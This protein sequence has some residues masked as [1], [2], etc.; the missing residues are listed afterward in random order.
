MKYALF[1]I[2]HID[3][4]DRTKINNT[5]DTGGRFGNIFIRNIVS[6]RMAKLNNLQ[7]IYDKH[8]EMKNMGI[9]LYT[10]GTNTYEKTLL[11]TD[12]NIDYILFNTK[13]YKTFLHG[14]NIFYRQHNYVP[15][16]GQ[17]H[18]WCQTTLIAKFIKEYVNNQ[19][20]NIISS[21]PFKEKYKNNNSVF[22]H[23]RLGDTINLGYSTNYEYYDKALSS[24]SFD[25][26]YI[27]SDSID[28]ETCQ[29][30]IKKYGLKIYDNNEVNTIQ[31]ASVN[32]Y[33]ILSSGTFSWLMGIFGFFSSIYYPKIKV[34]WHG[35]IFVFPEWNEIDF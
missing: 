24:I 27:S 6:S 25:K 31:F 1:R 9:S 13:C 29:N 22:V 3:K 18:T 11:I 4:F 19:Q 32:K 35:D 14:N 28:H 15:F 10:E 16:L 30:L 12:E 33:I 34:K 8:E 7:F 17:E 2:F 23:V 21:N 20:E 5:M 26:G